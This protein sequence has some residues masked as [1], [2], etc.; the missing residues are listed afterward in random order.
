ML[1]TVREGRVLGV[2]EVSRSIGDG[3]PSYP[4]GPVSWPWVLATSDGAM[5]KTNKAKLMHCL[6]DK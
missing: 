5:I 1:F 6:E 4:L 3:A 2:L